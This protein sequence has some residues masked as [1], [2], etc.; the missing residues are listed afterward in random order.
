MCV[1]LP[2]TVPYKLSRSNTA[3]HLVQCQEEQHS[4]MWCKV[5][6]MLLFPA[7]VWSRAR[8][9]DMAGCFFPR[10]PPPPRQDRGLWDSLTETF[11]QSAPAKEAPEPVC[12]VDTIEFC[13]SS[14]CTLI[15]CSLRGSSLYFIALNH[16][17]VTYLSFELILCSSVYELSR[18]SWGLK[19]TT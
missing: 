15:S 6:S 14:N 7:M 19:C 10:P 2:I 17:Y 13:L 8:F 1:C 16:A 4:Q 11:Q 12:H 18:I 9:S 5:Q 3:V